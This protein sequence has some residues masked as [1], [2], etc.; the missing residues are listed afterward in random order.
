MYANYLLKIC[1][2]APRCQPRAAS[3]KSRLLAASSLLSRCP[4]SR[5]TL[6]R[7][8]SLARCSAPR[9]RRDAALRPGLRALQ[10]DPAAAPAERHRLW[11]HRAGR[12]WLAAVERRQPDVLAVVALFT[13]RLRQPHG[14]WWVPPPPRSPPGGGW[15]GRRRAGRA[16]VALREWTKTGSRRD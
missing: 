9:R 14:V 12:P 11:H 15:G 6:R 5:A 7:R 10:M 1:S 13:R 8:P 2:A 16:E 4:R 3:S